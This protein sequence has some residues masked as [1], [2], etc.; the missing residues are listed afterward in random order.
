MTGT[1]DGQFG[2]LR[3]CP[4]RG[5]SMTT[6]SYPLR[7]SAMTGLRKVPGLRLD[8]PQRPCRT[9]PPRQGVCQA[10]PPRSHRHPLRAQGAAR[11]CR[12]RQKDQA[13]ALLGDSLCHGSARLFSVAVACRN[14]PG[15]SATSIPSKRTTGGVSCKTGSSS[16]V[17]RAN[18]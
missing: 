6:A 16:Q 9:A 2:E 5:G 1:W 7:S 8:S 12:S 4:S 15:G 3:L 11:R 18:R 13:R 10:A 14:A 17:S